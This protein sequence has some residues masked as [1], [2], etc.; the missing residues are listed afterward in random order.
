MHFGKCF[1]AV[2]TA[3]TV[4]FDKH[5]LKKKFHTSDNDHLFELDN[6]IISFHYLC[7]GKIVAC[8]IHKKIY[9][10]CETCIENDIHIISEIHVNFK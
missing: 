4:C 1:Q 8:E 3:S 5:H 6:V 2:C 9:V 7:T 10:S